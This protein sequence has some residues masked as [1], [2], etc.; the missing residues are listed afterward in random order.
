MLVPPA[1]HIPGSDPPIHY[2]ESEYILAPP[3]P[4]SS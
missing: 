2:H 4:V 1:P 3:E